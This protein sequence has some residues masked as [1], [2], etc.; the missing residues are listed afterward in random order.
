MSNI[1][2][3]AG[4]A[5]TCDNIM[6]II[7]DLTLRL[8][9]TYKLKFLKVRNGDGLGSMGIFNIDYKKLRITETGDEY[10]MNASF[11]RI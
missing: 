5:H 1:A 4:L 11:G 2:E 10:N 9:N 3:S 6:A 8:D 7:Q